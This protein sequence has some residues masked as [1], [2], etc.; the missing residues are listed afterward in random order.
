MSSI[1][2][3]GFLSE[4]IESWVQKHRSENK[5][6]FDLSWGLNE[7]A[8]K[9]VLSLNPPKTD[10]QKIL[11]ILLMSR[12]LSH[13]Q[14]VLI[15]IER[16]MIAE[17]RSLLRGMLDATF[18]AVAISKHPNL[19]ERF[20]NDDVF[21][22]LKYVRSFG[23]LPKELRKLHRISKG[24]L[25]KL[26][27]ELNDEIK[28]KKI[29]PL[30]SEFLAQKAGMLGHYNTLFVLLSSST[31]SRVRDMSQYLILD[32]EEDLKDLKWGPDVTELDD[33]IAPACECLFIVI[34]AASDLYK[35]TDL[36]SKLEALWGK[37]NELINVAT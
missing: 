1:E 27:K 30:T 31:H 16:G 7:I 13:F 37:Y 22:R 33:T 10:E 26:E 15:L 36:D 6:W 29:T 28:E 2:K 5:E 17:S 32:S 23:S 12:V 34:R 14:G 9:T 19:V 24:S 25:K 20:V 11:T 8:Q 35:Y 4:D 21:Q 18:S 3:V